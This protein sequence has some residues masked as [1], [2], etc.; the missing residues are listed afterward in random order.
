VFLVS[1]F[2]TQS[3]RFS[4]QN[5]P[6]SLNG[7]WKKN[8]YLKIRFI[9]F[10]RSKHST[11]IL[12]NRVLYSYKN[13]INFRRKKINTYLHFIIWKL[14]IL[15]VLY[16]NCKMYNDYNTVMCTLMLISCCWIKAGN[17][18]FYKRLR[19]YSSQVHWITYNVLN[20]FYMFK[21]FYR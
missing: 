14:C 6:H 9:A 18:S 17:R 10:D 19:L 20:K 21:L 5:W 13:T 11:F 8:D 7:H 2:A 3:L 12:D 4:Q 15:H 1:V 16:L